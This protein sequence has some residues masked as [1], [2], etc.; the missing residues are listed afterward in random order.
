MSTTFEDLLEGKVQIS[1]INEPIELPLTTRE[2][3]QRR[4]GMDREASEIGLRPNPLKT[5]RPA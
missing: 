1:L 3:A 4:W 5:E 2:I